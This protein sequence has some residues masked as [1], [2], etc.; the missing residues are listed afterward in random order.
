MT[1]KTRLDI[2]RSRRSI[3]RYIIDMETRRV[4]VKIP[5]EHVRFDWFPLKTRVKTKNN[6]TNDGK[7]RRGEI[8]KKKQETT[9]NNL[10]GLSVSPALRRTLPPAICNRRR[11]RSTETNAAANSV[12]PPSV[13]FCNTVGRTLKRFYRFVFAVRRRRQQHPDHKDSSRTRQLGSLGGR[14]RYTAWIS[15]F[16]IETYFFFFLSVTRRQP[17]FS[18]NR[19]TTIK[20]SPEKSK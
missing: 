13:R 20:F 1:A 17:M 10:M 19:V 4:C 8:W 18:D 7:K 9:S 6:F 15:Q 5:I 14:A 3:Y 2:R 11:R 12:R 16:R